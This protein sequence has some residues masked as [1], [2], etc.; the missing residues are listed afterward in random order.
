M[1]KTFLY[2][3]GMLFC[4][5]MAAQTLTYYICDFEDPQALQN[6]VL[7]TRNESASSAHNW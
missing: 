3:V 5:L 4:Q 6:W 7:N 2:I 1:K